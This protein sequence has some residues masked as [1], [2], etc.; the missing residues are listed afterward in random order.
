MADRNSFPFNEAFLWQIPALQQLINLGFEYLPPEQALKQRL[1]KQGNLLLEAILCDQLKRINHIRYKGEGYLFSEENI[2]SALQKIK[3]VKYDGLQRTSQVIYDLL[4]LGTTLEQSIDGAGKSYNLNYI[5]WRNWQRNTFHVTAEFS[6]ERNR[7]TQCARP[8][9][10][11]FVNGIPFSVIECKAPHIEIKE[12][13]NQFMRNQHDDYIPRL[14]TYVQQ[15]V[16]VNK[17]EAK[18]AATSTA[19]K[20]WGVWKELSAEKDGTE[21]QLKKIINTPLSRKHKVALFSGSYELARSH[22]D[23]LEAA[24]D[25][26]ISEQDRMLYSLC[27]PE[28]LIELA[29]RYTIFDGGTKKIARYQQYFVVKSTLERVKIFDA[30]GRRKG[31]MIW[32]TQGSGKS[33]I[34]A[35]LARNLA[36]DS[37]IR[38]P[39]LVLVTDRDDLD[40]QLGNTFAACGLSPRRATSGKELLKLVSEEKAGIII[41]LIDKF[42][43]A[44]NVKEWQDKSTDIFVL[45]DESHRSHFGSFSARIRQMFPNACYLGFTG[46]PL[47]KKEK[48][49]FSK[50]GGLIEPHYSIE[51]AVADGAVVPLLYERRHVEMEQ[52]KVAIDLWFERHTDGLT[53]EQKADLKRKYARAEMLD[54]ADRLVYM[55]AFD[56]SEHYRQNFQGTGFKAQLVA[57]RKETALRYHQYLVELGHVSSAVII[58]APDMCEGYE[59]PEGEPMDEV[60]K[61]WQK[62]M[63]RYGDERNYTT[64]IINQFKVSDEPEILIVVDKLLTGFDALRNT[65]LYLCRTLRE[66]TLLQAVARVN[67]LSEDKDHGYIVDY[68]GELGELDQ[69][70]TMY[71]AFEGFDEQDIVRALTSIN[72]EV[73]KL[74]QRYS[75]LRGFFKTVKNYYDD[76]A[77]EELLADEVQRETFYELL[78]EYSKTLAISLS[79]ERFMTQTADSQIKQYKDDMVRFQRLR[80]LVKQRYQESIDYRD[81]EPRIQKLLDTHIQAHEVLQLNEPVNIFDEQI[82]NQV[83]EEQGVYS[84]STAAAR[85]DII[86]H[87]TKRAITEKMEQ[88]PAF[89]SQFSTL[90]RQA[91]DDYRAQRISAPEYLTQVIECRDNMINRQH[92]NVPKTVAGNDAAIAYFGVIQKCLEKF[93]LDKDEYAEMAANI[94]R[95]VDRSI[96]RHWKVG[97]WQDHDSQKHVKNDIDDYLYDEVKERQGVELCFELMNEIIERTMQVARHRTDV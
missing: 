81:Y 15:V 36:L 29:Y 51:Q 1:G 57:P 59:E 28:R 64:S 74:P 4:T 49:N 16:A 85:A 56:I 53:K 91:I 25:R 83:K 86:A 34:M 50:F 70:L 76:G 54:K 31:G 40:K 79:S 7:S 62:M 63:R 71:G 66:H 89:Y 67:R 12:A 30:N 93:D 32:H 58:S 37:E 27:R 26:V 35:M 10:V 55:R 6:L 20:F 72:V 2:Q 18:Y 9:I 23:V 68:V 11:L 78:T 47:L 84:V 75:D 97:F 46:T 95:G 80:G 96:Q 52:K 14:F 44:M 69:A 42:D 88:D 33:L 21:K 82:F 48:N 43:K 24:G 92:K 5:D 41:T 45:V 61:F 17:N 94:A 65:V 22:F 60:V 77:Y 13:I 73:A 39:R 38:Q 19:P 8:D 3:S 90:T 87:A